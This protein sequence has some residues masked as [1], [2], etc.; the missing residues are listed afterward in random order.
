MVI[1]SIVEALDNACHAS[2]DAVETPPVIVTWEARTGSHGRPRK[3]CDPAFLAMAVDL[4]GPAGL[5]PVFG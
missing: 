3:E 1:S 2:A 5:A 4:R